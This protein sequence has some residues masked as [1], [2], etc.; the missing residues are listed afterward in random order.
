MAYVEEVK[1]F[2]SFWLKKVEDS[3]GQAVWPGVPYNDAGQSEWP[4]YPAQVEATIDSNNWYIE[5]C[6]IKGGYNESF[7]A[8]GAKAY[9]NEENIIQELKGSSLIYSGV[10][11]SRTGLN[12]TNVF[13]LAAPITKSLDPHNGTIQKLFAEDTNLLIFQESKVSQALI[14]K[15]AIYS[16]EGS[17]IQTSSNV[18]I[19]QVVPYL[20]KYGIGEHPESFAQFGFRKYF[21][22]PIRGVACRLSRDGIT[23]ISNYGMKDYFRDVLNG[24]PTTN[25][26][27]YESWIFDHADVSPP[28]NVLEFYVQAD[29]CKIP[30]GSKITNL[31]GDINTATGSSVI[32]VEEAGSPNIV[33]ITVDVPISPTDTGNFKYSYTSKIQGGWDNYNKYYTVSIQTTP[34][35]LDNNP[36]NPTYSTL[37]FDD[38]IKG[39]VSFYSYKPL[40]ITSLRGLNYS[41]NDTQLWQHYAGGNYTTF[42]GNEI[43]AKVEFI[44]NAN[45]SMKKVFKTINY[46]GDNGW[47]VPFIEGSPQ[48]VDDGITY[49]D[50][51][52]PILSYEKGKYSDPTTGVIHHAGFD[53]KENLYVSELINASLTRPDEVISGVNTTGIKG[54][55]ANIT[56]ATDNTTDPQGKKIL[57]GVGSNFVQ[58][59]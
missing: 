38:S 13:S 8:L 24:L 59:S 58:S 37:S 44:L 21:I 20:G 26:F 41:L 49:M 23:E 43:G 55:F 57:W 15:D 52:N 54:Y 31:I 40:F 12:Q 51:A 45:P 3:I 14:D 2:N 11:N 34:A 18:V 56:L 4:T 27:H 42:Y 7:Y 22:D 33:K 16:A 30:I 25:F 35:W 53:R 17:P 28:I 5:E 19:G 10:Y 1:Y 32:Q 9:L 6:R 39:W 36:Y 29:I 48:Q 46:E 47:W 50:V